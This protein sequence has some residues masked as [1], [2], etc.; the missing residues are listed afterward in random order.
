MEP[1]GPVLTPDDDNT[2]TGPLWFL[3]KL[4]ATCSD[5]HYHQFVSHLMKTHLVMETMCI[6]MKRHLSKQHPLYKLLD[7]HFK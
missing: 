5:V 3:A 1:E 2:T 7:G 6:A 4:Y